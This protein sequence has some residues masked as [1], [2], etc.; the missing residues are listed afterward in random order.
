MCRAW[1]LTDTTPSPETCYPRRQYFS[2]VLDL[3]MLGDR[4]QPIKWLWGTW[5]PYWACVRR[6]SWWDR[7]AVHAG[8]S[9]ASP[10][11]LKS[12]GQIP[13]CS[14]LECHLPGNWSPGGDCELPEIMGVR[15]LRKTWLTSS[16][17]SM[18]TSLLFWTQ[19]VIYEYILIYKSNNPQIVE[20]SN[21][22]IQI[23]IGRRQGFIEL[24]SGANSRVKSWLQ[25]AL[26]GQWGG[27]CWSK[28]GLLR[29]ELVTLL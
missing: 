22:P 26:P 11:G 9:W 5:R 8:V 21:F 18:Y 6:S 12:T 13:H 4:C 27:Q 23:Y 16:N 10:R 15:G 2:A 3:G 24:V 17:L 20:N 1:G 19:E 29:M 25:K 28:T 14:E 7:G